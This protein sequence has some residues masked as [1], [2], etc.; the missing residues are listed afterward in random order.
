MF[1]FQYRSKI[2]KIE[3]IFFQDS[4]FGGLTGENFRFL[5]IDNNNFVFET[6]IL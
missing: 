4:L 6:I 3:P 2:L 1:L 5:K